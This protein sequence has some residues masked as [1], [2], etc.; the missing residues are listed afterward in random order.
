M[1]ELDAKMF[2]AKNLRVQ[3]Q[4]KKR[5]GARRSVTDSIEA[6]AARPPGQHGRRFYSS[7]SRCPNTNDGST[8]AR[9]CPIQKAAGGGMLP[10]PHGSPQT[11]HL[12]CGTHFPVL[13]ARP[14]DKLRERCCRNRQMQ[15]SSP[16]P[17]A[18]G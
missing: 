3:Q 15:N 11:G 17:K 1:N 9:R 7:Q 14:G 18:E 4:L 2:A 13:P 10:A 5:S 6:S 12:R 16:P 8:A